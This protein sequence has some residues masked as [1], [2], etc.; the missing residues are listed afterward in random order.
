MRVPGVLLGA[1]N[2]SSAGP[3]TQVGPGFLDPNWAGDGEV[4]AWFL[5]KWGHCGTL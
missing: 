1:I 2:E 4:L 3:D 5:I